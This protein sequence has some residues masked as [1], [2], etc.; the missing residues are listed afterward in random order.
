M[1]W[2]AIAVYFAANLGIGTLLYEVRVGGWCSSSYRVEAW[3]VAGRYLA[4]G[5]N[6]WR[7]HAAGGDRTGLQ[8]GDCRDLAL[9]VLVYAMLF[10]WANLVLG[11]YPLGARLIAPDILWRGWPVRSS[12][13]QNGQ[14][15]HLMQRAVVRWRLKE[16]DYE[17]EIEEPG[18]G[19][20]PERVGS[21]ER[22][23][24]DGGMQE[25]A[26]SCAKYN[27][28]G[29]RW[30]HKPRWIGYQSGWIGDVSGG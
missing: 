26:S 1:D 5:Y 17:D 19:N 21:P 3:R 15:S 14:E 2:L 18:V 20:G 4:G 6:F 16:K 11:R 28:A 24:G 9:V 27:D 8:P 13:Q 29:D 25:R 10:G 30:N 23:R 12:T 7:R 22:G